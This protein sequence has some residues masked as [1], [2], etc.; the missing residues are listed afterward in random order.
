MGR[1]TLY[2]PAGLLVSL[3][4]TL[5]SVGCTAIVDTDVGK[6]LGDTCSSD[7][8][9]QGA[10]CVDG[11]C[12][13]SCAAAADCPPP[14]VCTSASLC[15]LPLKVGFIYVGVVEDEGWTLTHEEGRQV[16]V[17][18]LPFL[19]TDFV[20]NVFLPDD[21]LQAA[22]D[23]VADGVNVVVANSFSLRGPMTTAAETHLN[24]KFLTC[25]GNVRTANHGTYFGRMEQAYHLAGYAAAHVTTT[26]RLGFVGS[27]ITPEVVRHINAFT[28]GAHRMDSSIVVEVR[29][30]GFWFDLDEPN[31][32]G[33]FKETVLAEALLDGGA[34]V[35]AHNMDNGR[36]LAAVEQRKLDTGMDLYCLGNDN[37]DACDRGPTTCIGTSYWNWGPL[38]VN[39]FDQ[40]H[41]NSW[42][43]LQVINENIRSNPEQSIPN[44]SVN[45]S[46]GGNDLAISVSELLADL[47][48]PGNEHKSFEVFGSESEYCSTGQREP[49]CIQSGE[50]ITDDELI[51]MCWFVKGVVEKADPADPQSNDIDAQVPQPECDTQ[52]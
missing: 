37:Y 1:T 8:D 48:K 18:Q 14:S 3:L 27:F 42:D 45:T 24:T 21:A 15:E 4:M 50:E 23:F 7:D 46:V 52:Q 29:W 20:S 10:Q 47:A 26:K 12:A 22:D 17:E 44:F 16:A 39:L 51:T 31:G 32:E 6:G 19:T 11:L 25:S 43:P 49:N 34:D 38:Y 36:A 40:I 9:C 30:E 41:R 2:L 5:G 33:K 13:I 28:R 35:I